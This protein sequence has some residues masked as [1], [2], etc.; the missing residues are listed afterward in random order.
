[1]TYKTLTAVC[2][3][4]TVLAGCGSSSNQ[5][6]LDS[7]GCQIAQLGLGLAKSQA[8]ASGDYSRIAYW[9]NQVAEAC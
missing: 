1:M 5:S 6:K 7:E 3:I 4:A 9:Q 8:I 2:L